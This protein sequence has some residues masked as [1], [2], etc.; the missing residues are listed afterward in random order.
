[1]RS[2]SRVGGVL[3]QLLGFLVCLPGV[4]SAAATT[5]GRR[6][7]ALATGANPHIARSFAP[8]AAAARTSASLRDGWIAKTQ[9]DLVGLELDL[10]TAAMSVPLNVPFSVPVTLTVGGQ[11]AASTATVY[12]DDT[13][14]LGTLTSPGQDAP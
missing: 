8:L 12:S 4:H 7:E 14:L 2:V 11:P 10:P 1:M 6:A 13:P 5:A 3:F 9:L